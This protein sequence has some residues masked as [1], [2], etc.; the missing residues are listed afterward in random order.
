MVIMSA[1]QP[2][3]K[4]IKVTVCAL[5]HAM[6]TCQVHK[7]DH[8][9]ISLLQ[10]IIIANS[11]NCCPAQEHGTESACIPSLIAH[12]PQQPGHACPSIE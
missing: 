5:Q 9:I 3:V 12:M 6:L 7:S 4:L 11:Q 8:G 10:L 2:S 1:S